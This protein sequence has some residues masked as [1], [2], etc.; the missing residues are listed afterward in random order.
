M[1][2]VIGHVGGGCIY[3]QKGDLMSVLEVQTIEPR[4]TPPGLAHLE[5]IGNKLLGIYTDGTAFLFPYKL[6]QNSN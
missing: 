6:N 4:K 3:N 5:I 1:Q 2:D